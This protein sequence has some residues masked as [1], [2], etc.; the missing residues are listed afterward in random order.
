MSENR[1]EDHQIFSPVHGTYS[2]SIVLSSLHTENGMV[3]G[4]EGNST[5]DKIVGVFIS[6]SVI[7]LRFISSQNTWFTTK[8]FFALT[9]IGQ[10]F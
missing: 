1:D 10:S 8:F 3:V 9:R 2:K 5:I 6:L 4:W 7:K